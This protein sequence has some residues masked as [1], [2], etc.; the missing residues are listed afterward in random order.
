MDGARGRGRLVVGHV[1][2]LAG[3]LLRLSHK[4]G[5]V[6]GRYL[7]RK[8]ADAQRLKRIETLRSAFR[9]MAVV[10][11]GIVAGMIVLGE[12]GISIAPILA[13]AGVAGIAIGFGAQSLVRDFFTGLF[14]LVENQISEGDVMC[15]FGKPA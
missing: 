4:L 12:L 7:A 6:F 3:V 9:N 2:L 15:P 8:N 1:L 10:V 13:T 11:I 14:L 5:E